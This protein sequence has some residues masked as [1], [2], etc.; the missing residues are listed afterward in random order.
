[1]FKWLQK[2]FTS[3]PKSKRYLINEKDKYRLIQEEFDDGKQ[4]WYTEVKY[5]GLNTLLFITTK[6]AFQTDCWAIVDKSVSSTESVA[7]H[8]YSI[9]N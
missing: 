7:R 6:V 3:E 8:I 4:L 5:R 9:L 2:L 1:M